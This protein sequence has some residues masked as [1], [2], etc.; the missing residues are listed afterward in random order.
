M[1]GQLQAPSVVS[2]SRAVV[3]SQNKTNK[4]VED[5]LAVQS[6]IRAYQV[7]GCMPL[8]MLDAD[9]WK[10][11]CWLC[12]ISS[13]C[14]S[15]NLSVW[16]FVLLCQIIPLAQCVLVGVWSP[17]AWY[18]SHALQSSKYGEEYLGRN[19]YQEMWQGT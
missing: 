17:Y 13:E 4:L 19:W 8:G 11:A 16:L 6:L 2:E 5:H 18:L 7:T 12:V 15:W 10:E 1:P 9:G 3:S 14:P